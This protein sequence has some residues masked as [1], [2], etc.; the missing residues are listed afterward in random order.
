MLFY[1]VVGN[2]LYPFLLPV[3]QNINVP[4]FDLSCREYEVSVVQHLI[5][6]LQSQKPDELTQAQRK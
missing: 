4:A 5:Q 6:H 1:K 3:F 2:L